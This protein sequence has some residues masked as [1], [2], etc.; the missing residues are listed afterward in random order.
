[1]RNRISGKTS[2]RG[3]S[4]ISQMLLLITVIL[5]ST[6]A[7]GLFLSTGF[8]LSSQS[9]QT[10]G[11]VQDYASSKFDIIGVIL[12]DYEK[13]QDVEDLYLNVKLAP[14]SDYLNL[15]RASITIDTEDGRCDLTY[16]SSLSGEG[17]STFNCEKANA[18]DGGSGESGEI[19]DPSGEFS[20]ESPMMD[21][22]A[23]VQ[24]HVDLE[25]AIG[26]I[27]TNVMINIEIST[28]T[29]LPAYIK[30]SVPPIIEGEMTHL[31]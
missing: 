19:Y 27:Q 20:L 31:K 17:A 26:A 2:D 14:G 9:Q 4:G 1:M 21:S 30:V 28:S 23:I 7:A 25:T 18:M 15:E 10:S 8:D 6:V 24:L 5:I 11:R 12:V 3:A 22:E 13:D 29:S 16:S